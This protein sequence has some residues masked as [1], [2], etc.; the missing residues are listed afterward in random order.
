MGASIAHEIRNPLAGIS[1]AVQVLT[2]LSSEEKPD[3]SVLQEVRLLI[4]RIEETVVRMLEY[5]KDW[6]LEP[7][8][9]RVTDLVEETVTIYNRQ[10]KYKNVNIKVIGS[11]DAKAL[12]D[13]D[14]ISQVLINLIENSVDACGGEGELCWRISKGLREVS[15]SLQDNGAGIED[16]VK[17]NIFKP[18]FTTKESGNGLGLAICQKIIEKHNGTISVESKV[19]IGS[20][21]II[22]LPQSKFLKA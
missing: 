3:Y 20:K 15:I 8:L 16:D 21:V 6:Q 13:P 10:A 17:N 22:V 12:L 19:G 4:E 1:G 5:A 11:D 18:F 9:C 7:Q 14:L 2:D